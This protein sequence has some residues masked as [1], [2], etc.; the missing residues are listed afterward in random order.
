MNP[1][2]LFYMYGIVCRDDLCPSNDPDVIIRA[3]IKEARM[4][5]ESVGLDSVGEFLIHNG[6]LGYRRDVVI[7]RFRF[8]FRAYDTVAK[9]KFK[10]IYPTVED[11]AKCVTSIGMT[12][13]MIMD[14]QRVSEDIAKVS[15]NFLHTTRSKDCFYHIVEDRFENSLENFK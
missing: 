13:N 12:L 14:Y 9:N 5:A 10:L 11:I 7:G 4:M 15:M 1:L 2:S 8:E 6:S 3:V